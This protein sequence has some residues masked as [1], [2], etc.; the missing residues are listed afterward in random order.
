MCFD[1]ELK[2]ADG[3]CYVVKKL[4]EGYG[5]FGE[6]QGLFYPEYQDGAKPATQYLTMDGH[7]V[8]V[9]CN[10]LLYIGQL[11]DGTTVWGE[12]VEVEELK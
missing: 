11:N 7:H 12:Q 4:K 1:T 8:A 5:V 3:C 10:G 6:S 9:V 2:T